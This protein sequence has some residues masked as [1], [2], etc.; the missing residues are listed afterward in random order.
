[1]LKHL[2]LFFLFYS[3]AVLFYKRHRISTTATRF[4]MIA[5]MLFLE[6]MGTSE[7]GACSTLADLGNAL[8]TLMQHAQHFQKFLA[9][10]WR[11]YPCRTY[12][13]DMSHLCN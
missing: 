8:P 9:K 13:F 3:V 4:T 7:D 10:F 6:N 11:I 1:M 2:F 12:L 5:M